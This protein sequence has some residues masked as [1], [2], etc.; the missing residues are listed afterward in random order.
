M[1]RAKNVFLFFS[2]LDATSNAVE[3]RTSEVETSGVPR[4]IFQLVPAVHIYRR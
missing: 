4:K 2:V 3:H 1:F